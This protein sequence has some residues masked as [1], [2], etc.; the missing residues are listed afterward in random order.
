MKF[1]SWC[2]S[3]SSQE[4]TPRKEKKGKKERK[5]SKGKSILSKDDIHK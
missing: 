1:N 3:K 2:I 4:E 5:I